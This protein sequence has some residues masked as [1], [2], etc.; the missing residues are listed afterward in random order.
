MIGLMQGRLTNSH[1]GKIQEFPV[2]GWMQEIQVLQTLGLELLEWTI[3]L[4]GF[5]ENPFLFL[6]KSELARKIILENQVRVESITC[7]YFMHRAEENNLCFNDDDRGL[8]AAIINGSTNLGCKYIVIPLVDQ[9][10]VKSASKESEVLGFFLEFEKF[11][12][13]SEL[14]VAFESDFPPKKLA[15]F[16]DKFPK[17][18]FGVNYDMGNS[19]SLGYDPQEEVTNYGNRILNIHVKDRPLGGGT[20]VFGEG[21]VNFPLVFDQLKRISYQG[22]YILQ[23]ARSPVGDH[24]GVIRQYLDFI[25]PYLA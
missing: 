12:R 5:W 4:A 18:I 8:L 25:E 24:L 1:S 22:N 13:D 10:S 2:N 21:D 14:K 19:A 15:S 7:D 6:E 23:G 20:V 3:D 9:A 11:L 17:D 16:I